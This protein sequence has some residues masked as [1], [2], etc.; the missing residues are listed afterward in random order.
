VADL[1]P[2]STL[3]IGL[4]LRGNRREQQLRL[5]HEELLDP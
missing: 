1:D 3:V 2:A 5:N 4:A